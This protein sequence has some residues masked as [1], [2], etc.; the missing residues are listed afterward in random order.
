MLAGIAAAWPLAARAYRP[1]D[2]TD[3]A[4]AD[5]GAVEVE[6]EPVGYLASEGEE[7]LVAPDLVVNWGFAERWEA[8]VEGR[9][10]VPIGGGSPEPEPWIADAALSVK[11]V[12]R[13]GTLQD[14]DGPSVATELSALVPA[15]RD[16]GGLGASGAV[17]VS[18]RWRE[19]TIHL[20]GAAA[21]T[22]AHAPGAF[23][24]AILEGPD[25]WPVRP[26]AEAFV[27]A[28]RGESPT[29]SALA[30]AIW[31]AS[32][33]LSFD[34]AVRVAREGAV[35]TTELRLGLTCAFRVR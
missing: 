2:G 13:P 18:Q 12:L 26:V 22:R 24:S 34:A 28:Q 21:W 17:I 32:E 23:V 5:E 11:G 4:V 29:R 10:L 19:L 1:F 3:A 30:G 14:R 31:R 16:E 7:A 6:L 20:N 27:D 25:R 15:G 9:H 35:A 8:V 33:A